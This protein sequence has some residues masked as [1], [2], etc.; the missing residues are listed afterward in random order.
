MGRAKEN[1]LVQRAVFDSAWSGRVRFL[2]R[3]QGEGRHR[4]TVHRKPGS[5]V[6]PNEVHTHT[7]DI[8]FSTRRT[9]RGRA[10]R[11]VVLGPLETAVSVVVNRCQATGGV[12]LASRVSP[13][14]MGRV[15]VGL[16]GGGALRESSEGTW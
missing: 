5:L 8:L 6:S 4:P 9:R 14:G 16:G 13:G 1:L 12:I 11:M 10:Y 3:A 15:L 2:K 7:A